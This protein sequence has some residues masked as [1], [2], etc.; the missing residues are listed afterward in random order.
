MMFE[1]VQ[2]AFPRKK[3]RG[4]QLSRCSSFGRNMQV[5]MLQKH[6]TMFKPIKGNKVP[7]SME[8]RAA[9]T[10]RGTI[11]S[12]SYRCSRNQRNMAA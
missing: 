9:L 10:L 2:T 3:K 7:I 4:F 6:Q 12:A 8:K 11:L 5:A 1:C